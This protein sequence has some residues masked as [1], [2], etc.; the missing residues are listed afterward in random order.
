M[1]GPAEIFG[2]LHE[3]IDIFAAMGIMAICTMTFFN[4]MM[5]V[6]FTECVLNLA[7]ATQ[8]E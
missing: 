1:T 3:K 6:F 8:A 4:C 7:M 5:Y 2:G